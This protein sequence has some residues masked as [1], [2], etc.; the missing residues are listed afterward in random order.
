MARVLLGWELGAN[1]GHIVTL[2]SL[3]SALLANGHEVALALQRIDAAGPDP[4]PRIRLWQAPLWPSLLAGRSLP[5]ATS[6]VSMGDILGR[7]GLA[8]QGTLS[9]LIAGWDAIFSAENPHL[10]IGD[11]APA[12][13]TAAAGRIPSAHI[14]NGFCLPPP[15]APRFSPLDEGP[16]AF[17]EDDLLDTAD[18]ELALSGRPPLRSLPALFDA[19]H[20]F[21]LSLDVLD[22]YRAAR[23]QAGFAPDIR[24]PVTV[25][26]GAGGDELF[27]YCTP[28]TALQPGFLDGLEQ[29]GLPV[30]LH[31]AEQ[32]V[33]LIT[34]IRARGFSFE[35]HPLP[36]TR[37]AARA[38]LVLSHGGSGFVSTALLSGLPQIVI[39]HDLEKRATGLA[40][41]ALG[42][43]RRMALAGL[44]GAALAALIRDV[45]SDGALAARCLSLLPELRQQAQRA[46]LPALVTLADAQG[47]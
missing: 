8:Q 40:V 16:P 6:P 27:V 46:A 32:P 26:H 2:R 43:G 35:A 39:D 4:D 21:V 12:L 28:A 24:G 44:D 25:G 31:M 36:F 38:R 34:Q 18:A 15:R 33:P 5:S 20:L 23:D 1:T 19:G 7:L 45:A 30:R 10:V 37:I 42:V 3:A 13:M 17:A 47:R 41:E 14:G 29:C 9:S 11:F 22:P